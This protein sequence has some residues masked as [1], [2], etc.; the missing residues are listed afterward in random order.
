MQVAP[1]PPDYHTIT[2]YLMARGATQLLEFLRQAFDAETRGA[3][4]GT[5]GSICNAEVRVG[6]SMLMVS[7]V[8]D[9][10]TPPPSM[11]YLY[12]PDTDAV[13]RQALDAGGVSLQEPADMFY[14]DR[15]AGVQ[16]PCGNQWWIA[17]HV[18][19]LTPEEIQQRAYLE[20]AKR[21]AQN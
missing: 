1:I 11:F 19:D 13:Y 20:E 16:D 2:P 9:D 6:N 4:L 17:T 7:E 14:G 21:E 3:T 18:E 10:S 15:N 5:N 12:V 8:R